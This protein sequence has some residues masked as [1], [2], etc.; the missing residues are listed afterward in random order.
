[1]EE[2]N[3]VNTGR[4]C[5]TYAA[6]VPASKMESKKVTNMVGT[7][8]KE[9]SVKVKIS[10]NEPEKVTNAVGTF[11]KIESV[12]VKISENEP[13]KVTNMVGTFLNKGSYGFEIIRPIASR[14][15]LE[16]V[17]STVATFLPEDSDDLQKIGVRTKEVY[18]SSNPTLS[19]FSLT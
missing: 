9:G 4:R 7:F 3:K 14:A 6:K 5:I 12:Q 17:A 8:L 19:I 18:I 10:E 13:E 16:K 11:L 1:M 15:E 2:E